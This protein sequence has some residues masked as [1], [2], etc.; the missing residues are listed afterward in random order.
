[1]EVFKWYNG[2][3]IGNMKEALS[4]SSQDIMGLKNLGLV[5]KW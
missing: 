1:M 2:Y 4:I 5:K 3:N